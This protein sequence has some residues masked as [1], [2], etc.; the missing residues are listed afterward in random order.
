[1]MIIITKIVKKAKAKAAIFRITN[2]SGIE[3]TN[4]NEIEKQRRKNVQFLLG[5]QHSHLLL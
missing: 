3:Q 2:R 5:I 4:E 1:M